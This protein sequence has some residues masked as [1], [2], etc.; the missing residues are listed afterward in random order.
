MIGDVRGLGLMVGVELVRDRA[1]KE[2]FPPDWKVGKRVGAATLERG[3]VSYPGTGTVDG[4]AGDHL[5]Y[6]PPLTIS[7]AQIDELIQILD[8]S[9][10]AVAR[11]LGAGVRA[12]TATA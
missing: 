12:A 3:L 8:A 11:E 4:L 9:L 1:T 10:S 5:L 2:P 6:A 7:T